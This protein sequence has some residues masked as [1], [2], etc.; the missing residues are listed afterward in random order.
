MSK[1]LYTGKTSSDTI[2]ISVFKCISGAFSALVLLAW[3]GFGEA[4]L[5]TV[6]L[7]AALGLIIVM[8]SVFFMGALRLDRYRAA[9]E[10]TTKTM[11]R[12]EFNS[13]LCLEL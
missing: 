5:Y 10:D 13:L 9:A 2:Y 6:L 8:Q 11:I 4:S 1:R 12:N 7:G 3:G